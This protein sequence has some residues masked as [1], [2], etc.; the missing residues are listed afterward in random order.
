MCKIFKNIKNIS[1][2][3]LIIGILLLVYGFIYLPDRAWS[4]LY[5]SALFFFFLALG[6]LF[7]LALQ[8]V[9]KS[10]W[11]VGLF[12]VMESISEYIII[13]GV[14]VF[15]ILLAGVFNLHHIFYWM[16]DGVADINSA[17]FDATIYS[18]SNYLNKSFFIIRSIIYLLG[19]IL[20][21]HL[22][23][24]YSIELYTK[25][26]TIANTKANTKLYINAFK[27]SVIFIV[28]F[29]ITSSTSAWDWIMSID[30]HWHSTLFGWYVFSGMFVSAISVIILVV[31]YLKHQNYLPQ[32]NSNQISDL[33]KYVFG[34][35]MFWGYLW[36]SQFML[37]WYSNIPEEV[38]YYITRFN[39]FKILFWTMVVLNLVFPFLMLMGSKQKQNLLLLIITSVAL[40]IGHYIDLFIMI[41]PGALSENV[42]IELVEIG[43]FMGIM[44]LFILIVFSALTKRLSNG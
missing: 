6:T 2:A 1:F 24:K 23:K 25:A 35:S 44:G 29:A 26:S 14:V 32:I 15:V 31:I 19:W 22:L 12:G 17:N 20:C 18:K 21:F 43:T 34:F 3:F 40:I 16:G 7:F 13:G 37:Y 42:G 5:I 39:D 9:T 38:T 30:V 33:A 27:V 28:F 4:S 41:T 36:F 8:Y 11:A 10:E